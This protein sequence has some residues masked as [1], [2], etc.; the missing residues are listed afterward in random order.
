[1][2]SRGCVLCF[3]SR[4]ARSLAVLECSPPHPTSVNGNFV[5]P[6][7]CRS[8]PCCIQS[9]SKAARDPASA[10]ASFLPASSGFLASCCIS[11]VRWCA[12]ACRSSSRLAS[13][14]RRCMGR[15]APP[16]SIRCL[17]VMIVCATA[18]WRNANGSS[19]LAKL[20]FSVMCLCIC[21]SMFRIPSSVVAL[22]T[23]TVSPVCRFH[24]AKAVQLYK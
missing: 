15:G 5:C 18:A 11:S 14:Q 4:L 13:S 22:V 17:S 19:R 1:M 2:S 10:R 23:S 6:V 3:V 9:L 16:A 12:V 24:H 8:P 20:G 7:R 21:T